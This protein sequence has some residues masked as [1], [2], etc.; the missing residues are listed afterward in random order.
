[1]RSDIKGVDLRGFVTTYLNELRTY[2]GQFPEEYWRVFPNFF[3]RPHSIRCRRCSNGVAIFFKR[4]SDKE[5]ITVNDLNKRTEEAFL[6]YLPSPH[7]AVFAWKNAQRVKHIGNR[8]VNWDWSRDPSKGRRFQRDGEDFRRMSFIP[9][10]AFFGVLAAF[11]LERAYNRHRD[12]EN[13]KKL[14]ENLRNELETGVN[15]LVGKGNLLPTANWNSTISSGDVKLLIFSERSKLS[16]I[17]FQIENHNY[18]AK[19]VRDGAVIAQTGGH[20]RIRNGMPAA[21]AYWHGLSE[22]LKKNEEHLKEEISM[23]LKEAWLRKKQTEKV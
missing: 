5:S 1:M 22:S 2:V 21:L 3:Y 17:Y 18:E 20:N 16:S 15:L 19:R 11:L 13:R 23:L 6:P 4:Q 8:I 10:E 7:H 12:G 14:M 9:G